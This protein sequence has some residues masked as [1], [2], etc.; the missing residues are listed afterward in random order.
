MCWYL[1]YKFLT[2][3][4]D[5]ETGIKMGLPININQ[6]L[7]GKIVEWERI[8]FKKGWNP[9]DVMHSICAFA[10]DMHNWG[11]GYLVIGI[12][13]ENG[14]PVFPP[15]GLD[16]KSID[17]IQKDLV[18]LTHKIDP[19]PAAIPQ[20]IEYMGKIVLV[21][22]VPGGEYRPY[23]TF[24]SLNDKNNQK[25]YYIR[26]GS[27]TKKAGTQEEQ[28]LLSLAAKVPFDDRICHAASIDDL[29]LLYIRD[30]LRKIDSDITDDE[31][32]SMPFGQLC[33]QMQIIGGTPEFT[34]P[35]NIGLLF[36]SDNPEKYIP[37]A[38]I[39]LVR[40]YDDIGDHFDE[41]IFHGPIHMQLQES[42]DF[43]RSQIIVEKVV[44]VD[45]KAEANRAF[46]Y[47][48]AALEEVLSNA[49]YHKSYDDRN[50]IEVRIEQKSIIVYNIAGPMPPVTNADLQKERVIA[51]SYRNR[52]IGDFLKELDMTE[53]R[54][55][56]FP[57]IY[58]AMRNNGSPD[59]IFKTDDFNQYFLAELPI[60]PSF[61]EE[62]N[63]DVVKDVVKELS[64]RQ[65]IIVS[66]MN[67]D[68]QISAA[69]LSQIINVNVRTVQR[70]IATLEKTGVISR[71]A[72][73]KSGYWK[74]NP[75]DALK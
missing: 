53:G 56:G 15:C 13:E 50:P 57:K 48:Y 6:L 51:R 24:T 67:N 65:R 17:K 64:D 14:T 29:D 12:E 7:S 30:F 26:Q 11:G 32:I 75:D 74:V 61:I 39:E 70:E 40:F 34:K 73:R 25:A 43:L 58:R 2:L 23:K 62:K 71:M 21:I 4:S 68:K 10:N 52:R 19:L 69:E 36:F 54:S 27:V 72:G 16:I 38:R 8:D 31:A 59:P 37:Y 66:L 3:H 18:N 5:V 60:H 1:K 49:V 35:K 41:K 45:D 44:K 46:N 42:L 9:E 55:T 20:P 22:W 63:K 33:W 47:P 28:L